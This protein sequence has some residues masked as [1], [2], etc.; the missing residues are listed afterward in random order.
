MSSKQRAV[1]RI[2]ELLL[3]VRQME[4]GGD[5]DR[6]I[7]DELEELNKVAYE[8]ALQERAKAAADQAD[9][10]PSGLSGVRR[11]QNASQRHARADDQ[12]AKG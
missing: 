6:L 3:K 5:L 9:F 11:Q 1:K 7:L 8:S 4:P 10:P 2:E 12:D